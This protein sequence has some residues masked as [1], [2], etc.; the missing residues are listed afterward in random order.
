[1]DKNDI[2]S[3]CDED[4][5]LD[6]AKADVAVTEMIS[7]HP[8]LAAPGA[9]MVAP[10]SVVGSSGLIGMPPRSVI[11]VENVS[12]APATRDWSQFLSDATHAEKSNCQ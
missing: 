12:A 1:M 9:P 10:A 6:L 3:L 7:L 8:H 2:A 5:A 11:D 4:G